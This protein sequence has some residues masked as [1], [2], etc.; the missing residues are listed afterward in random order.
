ML[1]NR[2]SCMMLY[3][4][5]YATQINGIISNLTKT[6]YSSFTYSSFYGYWQRLQSNIDY[7]RWKILY[8]GSIYAST[9]FIDPIP[10]NY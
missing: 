7:V 4:R 9:S 8:P 10:S 5:A 6:F 3:D 2:G 1:L